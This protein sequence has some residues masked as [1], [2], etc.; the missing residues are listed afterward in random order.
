MSSSRAAREEEDGRVLRGARN[1]EAIARAVYELVRAGGVVPSI[2]EVAARAGVG[3]RTVFRQ[4]QDVESL[5][6]SIA[7]RLFPEVVAL[8]RFEPPTGALDGDVRSLVAR[9]ARV[10]EHIT[11]FRRASAQ[12]RQRSPFLREQDAAMARTMRAMLEAIVR[13]HLDRDG[14]E[15]LEALDALLSFEAWDRLR[16]RQGLSAKRAEEVLVAAVEKLVGSRA[17]RAKTKTE[18]SG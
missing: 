4:F 2:E 9:R 1:R 6:Q 18:L 13:P 11:P 14:P 10:F 3:V 5:F 8:A 15:V 16:D 7:E 12:L 17:R